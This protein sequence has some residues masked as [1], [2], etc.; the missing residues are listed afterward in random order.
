MFVLIPLFLM[1][2][3]KAQKGWIWWFRD[4]R[5]TNF[6][7]YYFASAVFYGAFIIEMTLILITSKNDLSSKIIKYTTWIIFLSIPLFFILHY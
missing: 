1:L 5:R 3:L 7:N 2:L 4:D 6:H